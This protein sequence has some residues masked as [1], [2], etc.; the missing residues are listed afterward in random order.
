MS[1][2]TAT[3][4]NLPKRV[5]AYLVD[6]LLMSLL[7]L[8]ALA[9]T[10]LPLAGSAVHFLA[11]LARD[12]VTPAGSP[13]KRLAGLRLEPPLAAFAPRLNRSVLRNLPLAFPLL[14]DFFVPE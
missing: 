14:F 8:A 9:A 11:F 1:E 3:R 4:V 2:T 6:S 7:T 5:F 12:S 10:R 13:G